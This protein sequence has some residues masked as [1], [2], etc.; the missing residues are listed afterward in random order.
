[1]SRFAK[2]LLR[3]FSVDAIFNVRSATPV[4]VIVST[5]SFALR[6]DLVPSVPLYVSDPTAGGGRRINRAAFTNPPLVPGTT[7]FARQG[8]L[9]RN[10]L[11]G[12]G[13]WQLDMA[14]RRQFSL[15]ERFKLQ[16]RAEFFNLFNHPNFGD[17]GTAPQF[18]NALNSPQFGQSIVILSKSLG[19]GGAVGGGF[20]PLYQ[21]GGARSIQLALKLVF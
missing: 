12:F 8:T 20:N 3:D 21:V 11:L 7:T 2:A 14:L 4:N 19:T 6:P 1:M 18:T 13:M 5:A 10:A 15:T 17:P 16:F 9:G